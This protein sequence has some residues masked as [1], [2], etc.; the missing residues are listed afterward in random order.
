MINDIESNEEIVNYFNTNFITL[1]INEKNN[2]NFVKGFNIFAYPTLLYL[3]KE[4]EVLANLQ[5]YR[6]LNHLYQ[7]SKEMNKVEKLYTNNLIELADSDFNEYDFISKLSTLLKE[8]P[9]NT[10]KYILGS[11]IKEQLTFALPILMHFGSQIDPEI[12][13]QA[14]HK[15][16]GKKN[17]ALTEK[18]LICHLL[19]DNSFS[20]NEAIKDKSKELV[21]ITG[22]SQIKILAFT[23]AY[24]EL[25]IYKSL[26]IAKRE[27]ALVHSKSLFKYYPETKDYDLLCL[28]LTEIAK[29]EKD[30]KFYQEIESE[31]SVLASSTK[32]YLY[33]DILSI[34]HYA[35]DKKDDYAKDISIANDIAFNQGIKFIPM[36]KY[37]REYIDEN[38]G[39]EQTKDR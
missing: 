28:A 2:R 5:G 6:G 13:S 19:S 39:S 35:L 3:N 20:S 4:G 22:L 33:Y 15:L 1:Q 18:L 32:I 12:F 27:S 26:N 25:L 11:A 16:D 9:P 38:L 30:T 37:L 8:L 29:S 17:A 31:I 34:I 36:L 24:R 14:Y 7:F 23:M 10:Q 21:K